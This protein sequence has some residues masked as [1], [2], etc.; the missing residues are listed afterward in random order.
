MYMYGNQK[1]SQRM[2]ITVL[3]AIKKKKK[4][5]HSVQQNKYTV[6]YK[7]GEYYTVL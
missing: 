5:K 3:T 2:F 6:T 7:F 1:A 4:G